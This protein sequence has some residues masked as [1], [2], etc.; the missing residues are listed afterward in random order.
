MAPRYYDDTDYY[1]DDYEE[2]ASPQ[3]SRSWMISLSLAT[4]LA[5][6][7]IGDTIGALVNVNNR[8]HIEFGQGIALTLPC[9]NAVTVKP[10]AEFKTNGADKEFLLDSLFIS[11]LSD[12]C[13]KKL[14]QVKF[15]SLSGPPINIGYNKISG[16]SRYDAD[17]V[18]FLLSR[19]VLSDASYLGLYSGL[20]W[21][22]YP[23]A[24][25]LGSP[26][27]PPRNNGSG[28]P[29][30]C[31]G[32]KN[33][34]DTINYT[35]SDWASP[36]A[37]FC[38]TDNWLI[39]FQGYLE[40]P[41]T[42]DGELKPVN[43][44]LESFGNSELWIDEY[45]VIADNSTRTE[46]T[47]TSGGT[48]LRRG[49]SYLLDYWVFKGTGSGAAILKWNLDGSGNATGTYSV[50]PSSAFYAQSQDLI[51][52]APTEGTTD[53]TIESVSSAINDRSIKIVFARPVPAQNIR[54][55]TIETT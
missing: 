8:T 29:I 41:G 30:L 50:V 51:E 16:G 3:R 34:A 24:T 9:D 37:P 22:T 14:F 11:G 31:G 26:P 35:E 53:Y 6:V 52:I 40:M 36:P 4:I 23:E 21:Y 1:D 27:A 10:V 20:N 48:S 46:L 33:V 39:H 38:P 15:Y 45:R 2:V 28:E 32:E 18:K 49:Q 12:Q 19:K 25:G 5:L 13:L 17:S 7:V 54:F 44:Q 43:F 47:A 55:L 42:D